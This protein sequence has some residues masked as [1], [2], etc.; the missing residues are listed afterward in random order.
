MVERSQGTSYRWC[1][2]WTCTTPEELQ[3]RLE[4]SDRLYREVYP[5]RERQS[6]MTFYP[7]LTHSGRPY[8]PTLESTVWQWSRMAEHL[9][10]YLV[11]RCVDRS[12]LISLYNRGHYVGKIHQGKKV[13][14]LFDPEVGEWIIA[15][16]EGR[17]LSRRLATELSAERVKDLN[18][19]HRE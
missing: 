13:Y 17:Q 8:E 6:R 2:P 4:R 16:R 7:G 3:E 1:E 19:T 11:Q 14:V 15:D 18:V 10:T 5:Y 12:G 9:S